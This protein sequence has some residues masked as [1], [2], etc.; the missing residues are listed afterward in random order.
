MAGGRTS[1]IVFTLEDRKDLAQ[2][3]HYDFQALFEDILR[4]LEED[5]TLMDIAVDTALVKLNES[6]LTEKDDWTEE[7]A[8]DEEETLET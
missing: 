3:K 2:L 8:D 1:K 5:D 6:P 4:Q 7:E